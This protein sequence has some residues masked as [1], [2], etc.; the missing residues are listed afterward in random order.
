MKKLLKVGG[1]ADDTNDNR[2][3]PLDSPENPYKILSIPKNDPN[4]VSIFNLLIDCVHYTFYNTI[5]NLL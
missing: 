2:F 5:F 4:F 1:D 3:V